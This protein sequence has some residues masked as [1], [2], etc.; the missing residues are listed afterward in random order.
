MPL[1]KEL[2]PRERMR[3]AIGNGQ[4]D[5]VPCCPDI[6]NYIPA[7]LTGRPFFDIYMR[8]D[9]PLWRAYLDA[10]RYFGIDG[11]FMYAGLG[12]QRETSITADT[13]VLA[14]GPERKTHRTTWHTPDGDLTAETVYYVGDPPT[15]T[16]KPVRDLTA[17]LPKIRHWYAPITGCET[18]TADEMRQ[19]V[20]EL[21][22]FGMYVP[23]PGFQSWF[24]LFDGGVEAM[25][26]AHFDH[27]DEMEQLRRWTHD[28]AIRQCEMVLD[29]KPDFFLTGGSGSIT[30]QSPDLFRHYSLPTLKQICRMAKQAGVLTMIHSC[31]RE[32]DLCRVAAEETDLNCINPLEVPPM[33]DCDLA[34][35]KREFGHKLSLMG[36]LHTVEVMQRG[37]VRDVEHAAKAAIDAAAAGGG[38]I[39][40]TGDQCPVGTPDDNI[41]K[42]VEVAKTY[43]RY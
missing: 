21:A 38:F 34:A 18:S 41:R 32:W 43:G 30:L 29:Y 7:R 12:F 35:C 42:L 28:D 23:L 22:V 39:L 25:T 4:P 2:S 31:G 27:P 10:V 11:W 24:G 1:G 36:N 6:S 13:E 9:P 8:N 37:T 3:I 14:D 33:G 5:R 20:G 17:D 16:L 40:S 26:Y 15:T 19:E